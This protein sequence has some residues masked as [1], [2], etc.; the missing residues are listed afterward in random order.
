MHVSFYIMPWLLKHGWLWGALW[1]GV[2]VRSS[3]ACPNRMPVT[4]LRDTY[5]LTGILASATR[6]EKAGISSRAGALG[7]SNADTDSHEPGGVTKL[8][9]EL[10]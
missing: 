10:H 1:H 7:S 5:L 2:R 3:K 9:K 4:H 8:V 6:L